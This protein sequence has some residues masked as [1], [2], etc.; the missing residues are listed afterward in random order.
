MS[1]SSP[2]FIRQARR[3]CAVRVTSIALLPMAAACGGGTDDPAA[4][5]RL[6]PAGRYPVRTIDRVPLPIEVQRGTSLLPGS[7]QLATWTRRLTAVELRV[8]PS[9]AAEMERVQVQRFDDSGQVMGELRDTI[10]LRF[11]GRDVCELPCVAGSFNLPYAL[12]GDT[13]RF[14]YEPV[15]VLRP[16]PMYVFIRAF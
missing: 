16:T 8:E 13:V 15:G 14:Q 1:S 9:G 7:G 12:S 6:P 4:P 11:S 3:A 2:S 10:A 5:V